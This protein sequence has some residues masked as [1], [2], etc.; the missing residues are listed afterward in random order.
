MLL[1]QRLDGVRDAHKQLVRRLGGLEVLEV[2][3]WSGWS[4]VAAGEH[5][6]RELQQ[7]GHLWPAG[8]RLRLHWHVRSTGAAVGKSAAGDLGDRRGRAVETLVEVNPL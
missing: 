5:L 6:P 8:S 7:R 1:L 4:A 2:L 3:G